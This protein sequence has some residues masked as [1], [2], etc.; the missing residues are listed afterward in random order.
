MPQMAPMS[1]TVLFM[2]FSTNMMIM[3]M[4]SYYLYTPTSAANVTKTSYH[5]IMNWKW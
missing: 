1:W 5:N 4:L 2:M 3:A